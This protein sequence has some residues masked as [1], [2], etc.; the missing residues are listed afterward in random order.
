[1]A[2]GIAYA[3]AFVALAVIVV[4]DCKW[5]AACQASWFA[6][7]IRAG[8]CALISAA[9]A[10]GLGLTLQN[11]SDSFGTRLGEAALVALLTVVAGLLAYTLRT[12]DANLGGSLPLIE[13]RGLLVFACAFVGLVLGFLIPHG[14]RRH[15]LEVLGELDPIP[16][17]S[18]GRVERAFNPG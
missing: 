6:L 5:D 7:G 4:L 16:S 13:V 10:G 15:A 18:P 12:G 14:F 17:A 3:A 8:S 2:A 1:M 9:V 11:R